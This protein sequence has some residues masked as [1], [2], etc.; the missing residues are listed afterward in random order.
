[1]GFEEKNNITYWVDVN[2]EWVEIH[3]IDTD[4][5]FIDDERYRFPQGKNSRRG[6]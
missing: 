1:M 2:G 3:D 5:T 6:D 4:I